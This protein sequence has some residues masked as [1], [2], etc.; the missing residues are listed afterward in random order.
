MRN[1]LLFLASLFLFCCSKKSGFNPVFNIEP[2]FKTYVDLFEQEAAIRGID[3]KINNLIIKYDPSLPVSVCGKSNV[4]SSD[5]NVQKII[6][7]NPNIKCWNSDQELQALIFHEMGHCILGR[8]H[9]NG[10]LPNGSPRS[11]MV[12]NDLG[13][14]SICIYPIDGQPCDKSDRKTYYMDEL[15]NPS[16]S[17]PGWAK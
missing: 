15:F 10:L 16:T 14:F 1:L 4:I 11:I 9:D 13:L 2:E 6:S 3:M 17:V 12:E 8:S 7:I 5:N